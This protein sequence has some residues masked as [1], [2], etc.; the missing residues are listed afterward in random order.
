MVPSLFLCPVVCLFGQLMVASLLCLA[1]LLKILG[2]KVQT[3]LIYSCS[4][5]ALFHVR[6]SNKV[7]R[8]PRSRGVSE[9]MAS[10]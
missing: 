4:N 1:T 6:I 9:M 10:P 8:S 2:I 7:L 5:L 3:I